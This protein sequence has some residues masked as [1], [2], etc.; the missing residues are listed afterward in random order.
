MIIETGGRFGE[1]Y[2]GGGDVCWELKTKLA[3]RNSSR[4]IRETFIFMGSS[5]SC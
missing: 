4:A 5:F 2:R 1:S 3:A